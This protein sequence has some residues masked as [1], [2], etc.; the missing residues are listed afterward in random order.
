MSCSVRRAVEAGWHCA[1]PTGGRTEPVGERS[2]FAQQQRVDGRAWV[3]DQRIPLMVARLGQRELVRLDAVAQDLR[4]DPAVDSQ[5]RVVEG[6]EL[7]QA[8]VDPSRLLLGS[9]GAEIGQAVVE[10]MITE[11]RREVGVAL[12]QAVKCRAG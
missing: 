9:R 4:V 7:G 2:E 5:R 12:E 8:H 6:V 10:A 1:E 3:R 11:R